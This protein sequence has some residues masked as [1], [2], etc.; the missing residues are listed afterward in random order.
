[1]TLPLEWFRA[2]ASRQRLPLDDEDLRAIAAFVNEARAAL[3]MHRPR[4]TEGLEPASWPHAS[5]EGGEA[6]SRARP[7]A[8]SP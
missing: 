2:E 6:V 7:E 8:S 1:M 5:E 3:D 4:D